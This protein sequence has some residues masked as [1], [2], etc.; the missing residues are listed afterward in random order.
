MPKEIH[1]DM[2]QILAEDSPFY[3]T[4][5]KWV[6]EFKWGRDSTVFVWSPKT[7]TTDK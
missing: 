5:S 3:A 6:A 7:S 1:K 4:V 2:V